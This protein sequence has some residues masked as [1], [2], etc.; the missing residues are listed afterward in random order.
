MWIISED[1]MLLTDGDISFLAVSEQ[2]DENE[3]KYFVAIK[4][5]NGDEYKLAQYSSLDNCAISIEIIFNDLYH[6]N[7]FRIRNNDEIEE[8]KNEHN[9]C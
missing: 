8:Y 7:N 6:K 5:S 3:N 1:S 4:T 9:I 2:N